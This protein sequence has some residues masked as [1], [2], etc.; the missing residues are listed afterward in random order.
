M[1]SAVL[2]EDVVTVEL[3]PKQHDALFAEEQFVGFVGGIGCGKSELIC[4]WLAMRATEYPEAVHVLAALTYDQLA[5]VLEPRLV[6]TLSRFGVDATVRTGPRRIA[7][8]TGASILVRSIDRP[9]PLRGVEIDSLGTDECDYYPAAALNILRGR[10]RG[11]KTPLARWLATTSP[12]GFRE[13]YRIFVKELHEKPHLRRKYRLIQ[14]ET[15]DNWHLPP[16]YVQDLEDA[17]AA[18]PGLADQELRGQFVSVGFTR[19]CTTFERTKHVR[20]VARDP[21]RDLLLTFDFNV[22]KMYCHFAQMTPFG[23]AFYRTIKAPDLDALADAILEHA[24][25][26]NNR[27]QRVPPPRTLLYGDASQGAQRTHQTSKTVWAYLRE[28]LAVL[29][30]Q[31]CYGT[32]NPRVIDR[33]ATANAVFKKGRCLVDP[34]CSDLILDFERVKWDANGKGLDS[35]NK[36]E[37]HPFDAATYLLFSLLAP[38]A[39]VAPRNPLDYDLQVSHRA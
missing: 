38:S 6:E 17:Y 16:E 9:E 2:E 12:N 32:I 22:G 25:T 3:L 27:G 1:T 26:T 29:S 31:P 4:D 21:D 7:C 11:R 20:P 28:R 24:Y 13:I 18:T 8:D 15:R 36:D 30:P 37:T 33:V 39:F 10:L 35:T 19:A 5:I 34:S 14:A 23:V